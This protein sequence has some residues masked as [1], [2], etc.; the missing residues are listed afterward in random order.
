M[1]LTQEGIA[2]MAQTLPIPTRRQDLMI[3]DPRP[4]DYLELAGACGAAGLVLHFATTGTDALQLRPTASQAVWLVNTSLP[5]CSG[6]ELLAA[7]RSRNPHSAVC[8]VGDRYD[9]EDELAARRSGASLY[10][11]KSATES[12]L[13]LDDLPGW[14]LPE[15]RCA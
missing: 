10:V 2:T 7:L 11:C 8:L 1:N 3:V 14:R 4:Q 5:D 15:T 13:S 6:S 9:P 12:W